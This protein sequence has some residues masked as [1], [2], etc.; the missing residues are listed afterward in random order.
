MIKTMKR[1]IRCILALGLLA[2]IASHA[3]ITVTNIFSFNGTNGIGGPESLVRAGNNKF[4]GIT[5][6]GGPAYS[7]PILLV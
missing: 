4:Y 6:V 7:P 1:L 3:R 5:Q 2:P